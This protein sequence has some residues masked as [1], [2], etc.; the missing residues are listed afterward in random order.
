MGRLTT[1]A[2]RFRSRR[3]QASAMP[4]RDQAYSVWSATSCA[5]ALLLVSVIG[6]C[7]DGDAAEGQADASTT[8]PPITTPPPT[9]SLPQTTAPPT[10]TAVT[11]EFDVDDGAYRLAMIDLGQSPPDESVRPYFEVFDNLESKCSEDRSV[12]GAKSFTAR[13]LLV[14]G[15][16]FDVSVLEFM[17]AWDESIPAGTEPVPCSELFDVLVESLL[18]G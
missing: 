18:A 9:T 13:T 7:G 16:V 12:L 1:S 14:G 5:I 4:D 3:E 6:A 17:Q 10:S 2:S 15:G 11:S 8:L